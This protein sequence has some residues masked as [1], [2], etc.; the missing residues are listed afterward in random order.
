MSRPALP[1]PV[2][3]KALS[4]AADR[5]LR[6]DKNECVARS[7]P[8][9]RAQGPEHAVGGPKLNT[10]S[11]SFAF[12][13]NQ[14][15]VKGKRSPPEVGRE[16]TGGACRCARAGSIIERVDLPENINHFNLDGILGRHKEGEE[17]VRTRDA[18]CHTRA[19]RGHKEPR[20]VTRSGRLPTGTGLAFST[21]Q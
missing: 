11:S 2:E 9:A 10:R 21:S 12:E 8:N 6:A 3:A 20:R 14:L 17:V 15:V 16:R 1:T 19:T 13:D 18:L 5:G 4:V 7:W